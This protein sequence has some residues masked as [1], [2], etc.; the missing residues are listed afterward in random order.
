MALH[1]FTDSV[2]APAARAEF[3]ERGAT[4]RSDIT[5]DGF[6]LT[7]LPEVPEAAPVMLYEPRHTTAFDR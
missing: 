2:D 3:A 7:T 1:G 4:I 5:D 6:V